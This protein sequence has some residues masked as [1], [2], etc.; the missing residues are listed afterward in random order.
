MPLHTFVT[1]NVF[2]FTMNTFL[3]CITSNFHWR[4][5]YTVLMSWKPCTALPESWSSWI[6][7][8]TLFVNVSFSRRR[9]LLVKLTIRLSEIVQREVIPSCVFVSCLMEDFCFILYASQINT[10]DFWLA[11]KYLLLIRSMQVM[12]LSSAISEIVRG[13]IN[14]KFTNKAWWSWTNLIISKK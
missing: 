9:P 14:K 13:E 10:I 6:R 12:G 2:M 7:L 8:V 11:A 1:L 4:G 3:S 5:M